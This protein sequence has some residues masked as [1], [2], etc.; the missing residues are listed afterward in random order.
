MQFSN[1]CLS[2]LFFGWTIFLSDG[3]KFK[4]HRDCVLRKKHSL[5]KYGKKNCFM[6]FIPFF[7]LW[8]CSVLYPVVTSNLTKTSPVCF[9]SVWL[10]ARTFSDWEPQFGLWLNTRSMNFVHFFLF[11]IELC[12]IRI[13]FMWWQFCPILDAGRRV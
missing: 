8:C 3:I 10:T 4:V 1:F 6:P 12:I 11:F 13:V 5:A 2:V 7:F 9:N